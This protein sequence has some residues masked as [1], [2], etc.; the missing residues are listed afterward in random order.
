MEFARVRFKRCTSAFIGQEF[1]PQSS[2]P[3]GGGREYPAAPAH[4][5][6]LEKVRASGT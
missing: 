4:G 6:L 2:V 1:W 3:C 5:V